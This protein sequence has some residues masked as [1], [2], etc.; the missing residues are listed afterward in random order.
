[1]DKQVKYIRMDISYHGKLFPRTKFYPKGD[2][3]FVQSEVK[4]EY[5]VWF[6]LDLNDGTPI[7]VNLFF[8]DGK[9]CADFEYCRIGSDGEWM[10]WYD[11]EITATNIKVVYVKR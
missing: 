5:G 8:C 10:H 2:K 3:A 6:G 9:W 7:N 1:M 4:T 11:S